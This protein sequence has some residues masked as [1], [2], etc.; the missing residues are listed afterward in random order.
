MVRLLNNEI[1]DARRKN[2]VSFILMPTLYQRAYM[3]AYETGELPIVTGIPAPAEAK[4]LGINSASF[5][6][7]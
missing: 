2:K 6:K 1:V 4:T 7:P 3:L 5:R